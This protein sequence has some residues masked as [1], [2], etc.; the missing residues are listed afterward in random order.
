[1][2]EKEEIKNI[3]RYN[4]TII[5]RP[6]IKN[7][8]PK[9]LYE[10]PTFKE[11]LDSIKLN[12]TLLLMNK[13]SNDKYA[14]D[15]GIKYV[16]LDRKTVKRLKTKVLGRVVSGIPRNISFKYNEPKQIILYGLEFNDLG[17][18][19]YIP[20]TQI[21]AVYDVDKNKYVCLKGFYNGMRFKPDE[22]LVRLFPRMFKPNRIYKI[23]NEV[24]TIYY[25]FENE[26]DLLNLTKYL[27]FQ[28]VRMIYRKKN[29]NKR[30]K[31]Y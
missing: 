15:K 20:D 12:R 1:M 25:S 22:S 4:R 10:D 18:Y 7:A 9:D 19:F 29:E 21:K 23:T 13:L 24:L 16:L 26:N 14:N 2:I 8:P 31:N 27:L 30:N 3:M 6:R 28:Q 5:H 11:Y 17:T